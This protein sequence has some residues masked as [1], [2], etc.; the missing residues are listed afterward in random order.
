M[1]PLVTGPDKFV[2]V[3]A[4][5]DGRHSSWFPSWSATQRATEVI[6]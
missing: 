4:G 2:L 5:G 6:G 3:V 1:L